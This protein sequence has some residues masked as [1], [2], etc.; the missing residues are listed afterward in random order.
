MNTQIII[1][2]ATGTLKKHAPQILMGL[3]ITTGIAGVVTACKQTLKLESVIKPHTDYLEMIETKINTEGYNE[4]LP[5][6]T[7]VKKETT[8]EYMR[9]A[10]DVV[11]LYALPTALCCASVVSF[12]SAYKV[13]NYRNESLALAYGNLLNN[14]KDYRSKVI[15]KYGKDIDKQ[16][17]TESKTVTYVDAD[18]GEVKKEYKNIDKDVYTALFDETNP[19]WEKAANFNYD[20]LIRVQSML[21][22]KLHANGYLTLNEARKALG[23]KPLKGEGLVLGWYDNENHLG[24]VDLGLSRDD[25]AVKAFLNG[26]ERSVWLDFLG[27][28]YIVDKM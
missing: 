10:T 14:F 18:N 28:E 9:L 3:G 17:L 15:E 1:A 25:A 19:N 2:K 24:Y 22:D 27:V 4:Q 20:F 12:C 13:L 16:I 23:F 21:N 26:E 8:K 7:A 5:D 6:D 11:K